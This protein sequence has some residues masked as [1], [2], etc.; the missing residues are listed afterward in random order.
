M[1]PITAE[2]PLKSPVP[3]YMTSI[4]SGLRF[5]QSTAARCQTDE[6]PPLCWRSGCQSYDMGVEA[7][8]TDQEPKHDREGVYERHTMCEPPK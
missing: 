3:T 8:K 1:G 4:F 5:A 7:R 6:N 2:T